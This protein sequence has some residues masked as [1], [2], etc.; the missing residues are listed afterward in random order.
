MAAPILAGIAPAAAVSSAVAPV[1]NN[2]VRLV[3]QTGQAVQSAASQAMSQGNNIVN[4]ADYARQAGTLA[5]GVAGA[6]ALPAASQMV[7]WNP[8]TQTYS[9]SKVRGRQ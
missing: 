2:I 9:S 4:F 7:G 5:A 1:A 6:V 8:E 3:P